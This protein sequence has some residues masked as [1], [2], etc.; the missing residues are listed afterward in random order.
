MDYSSIKSQIEQTAPSYIRSIVES[1]KDK[2]RELYDVIKLE[3]LKQFLRKPAMI[4]AGVLVAA[5]IATGCASY[6]NSHPYHPAT[7]LAKTK[8]DS[9]VTAPSEK[10]DEIKFTIV[11]G[12]PY[13]L[14]PVVKEEA[15]S[16]KQDSIYDTLTL[17][18]NGTCG[19]GSTVYSGG[20]LV[21][22]LG[23]DSDLLSVDIGM[24]SRDGSSFNG[25][26]VYRHLFE[27]FIAG[28]NAYH[29]T[30][31]VSFGGEILSEGLDLRANY[32]SALND[33]ELTGTTDTS[34][35]RIS[36]YKVQMSGPEAE[37]GVHIP[38][39]EDKADIKGIV[40]YRS[41][42][43]DVGDKSEGLKLGV[44]TKTDSGFDL[45]FIVMFGDKT[46]YS[47]GV[48]YNWTFGP[49]KSWLESRMHERTVR[50]FS[51]Y[52]TEQEVSRNKTRPGVSSGGYN[53]SETSES[54]QGGQSGGQEDNE[55]NPEQGRQPGDSTGADETNQPELKPGG[56]DDY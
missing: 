43:G 50:D 36:K 55:E 6:Q 25:G 20:V 28:A 27:N 9:T 53:S 8:P 10:S 41:L 54:G 52:T 12:K 1:G 33:A 56:S 42:K 21:P 19:N 31:S 34:T 14:V 38:V 49:E 22:A 17:H 46:E 40:G 3:N 29:D 26:I 24:C 2:L 15:K 7:H 35:K 23:N 5:G 45:D 32:Y 44:R 16:Q 11:D 48:S 4:T 37:A 30:E 13:K 51:N 39:L 47:G 18:A